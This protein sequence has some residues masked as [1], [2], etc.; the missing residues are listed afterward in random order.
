MS[1]DTTNGNKKFEEALQLL[2]EAA[3][4]KKDEIQGLLGDKYSHIKDAIQELASDKAKEFNRFK[5]TAQAAF[6]EGGEKFKEVAE[7]LDEKVHENPWSYI[8]GV[9]LGALLLGYI[10]GA[11][12]RQ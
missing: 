12:K 2:N 1:T 3:K 11:S 10:L 5:K 8:G 6:E 7:D 4:E 9:A